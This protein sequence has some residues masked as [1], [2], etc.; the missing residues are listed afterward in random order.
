MR[1]SPASLASLSV[2]RFIRHGLFRV[3]GVWDVPVSDAASVRP[4]QHPRHSDAQEVDAES[5]I[6][7]SPCAEVDPDEISGESRSRKDDSELMEV[8]RDSRRRNVT[9][10]CSPSIH[11]T[12]SPS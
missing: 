5:G 7:G 10:A 1:H 2:R 12:S 3:S 11:G 9:A 8:R 6:G 4:L